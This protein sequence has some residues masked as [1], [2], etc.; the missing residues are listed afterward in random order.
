M[1]ENKAKK[2][3]GSFSKAGRISAENFYAI[4]H[5]DD[6]LKRHKKKLSN[7][8]EIQ[9]SN[10]EY[11]DDKL[12]LDKLLNTEF[13]IANNISISKKRKIYSYKKDKSNYKYHDLHYKNLKQKNILEYAEPSCT[14]YNP[15][16]D[17]I[18][19]KLITGPKWDDLLGRNCHIQ[20]MENT[21]SYLTSP[22]LNNKAHKKMMKNIIKNKMRNEQQFPKSHKKK[23]IKH[24]KY[25]IID[26]G[27]SKCLVDM[28]KT[29]QR[30][31]I[32]NIVNLKIRTDRPF[33][34]NK[35]DKKIQLIVNL[36]KKAKKNAK[37][38][39]KKI[40][41]TNKKNNL[42]KKLNEEIK[43]NKFNKD[44]ISIN[45][46]I[47]RNYISLNENN[48]KNKINETN[49]DSPLLRRLSLITPEVY[50]IPE[51]SKTMPQE[52]KDNI[53]NFKKRLMPKISLNYSLISERPLSM[54][55]YKKS[56]KKID[57]RKKILRIDPS[58]NFDLGKIINKYNNHYM[59]QAPNFDYMTS[60]PNDKLNPLPNF[61]QKMFNRTSVNNYNDKA[62]QLNGYSEGKFMSS[63][64]SFFP[65][66]S[67]NSLIN[68]S[69]LRGSD[70]KDCNLENYN[71]I[72][73]DKIINNIGIKT[74][75]YKQLIL[76]G[77]LDKFDKIT[78]KTV[79]KNKFN[80]IL[81]KRL[82]FNE[83]EK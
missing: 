43:S 67:F 29:S 22:N 14:K 21:T 48:F 73:I 32:T 64:N 37:S 5:K 27:E 17:Y 81:L 68:L 66:T 16:Y 69:L 62:L 9:K 3:Y 79:G 46:K 51:I 38:E 23:N 57:K 19:K 40:I 20:N 4:I 54:V 36:L 10:L 50:E 72:Q 78:F 11:L 49:F 70:L 75:N 25:N 33:K 47:K 34:K 74:K 2:W 35:I 53:K 52:Q 44:N 59:P 77:D 45:N 56:Q 26:N 58:L 28:D 39:D 41:E 80:K 60:R 61:M 8:Y 18:H 55:V 63:Y 6:I 30:G 82:L 31:D 24:K 12:N 76:E 83:N 7:I 65:K 71:K 1:F 15:N 42:Q 13:K